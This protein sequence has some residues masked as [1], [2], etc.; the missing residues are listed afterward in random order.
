[1]GLVLGDG[2]LGVRLRGSQRRDL[3]GGGRALL[4]GGGALLHR[5]GDALVGVVGR[6]LVGYE[7]GRGFLEAEGANGD[8]GRGQGERSRRPDADVRTVR[9]NVAEAQFVSHRHKLA[10]LFQGLQVKTRSFNN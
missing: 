1:M 10:S 4:P 3:G 9:K 2:R 8:A 5:G 6:V 7:R